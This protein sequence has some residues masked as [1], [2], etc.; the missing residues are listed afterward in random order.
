MADLRLVRKS[1]GVI[2]PGLAFDLRARRLGAHI[3]HGLL[4]ALCCVLLACTGGDPAPGAGKVLFVGNS[5]TYVGNV[6]AVYSA[7]SSANGRESPS[8]MIVRGGATLAQRV[9]DG[10]VARALE[11]GAYRTLVIQERGGDLVCGF[12]PESCARSKEAVTSLARLG[13]EHQV[14]VLLLGTY[15]PDAS[16]SRRLVEGESMAAREAGIGYIE[17]SEKLQRLRTAAPDLSWFAADDFHPGKHLA[18][19]NALLVYQAV[20]DTLPAPGQLTV[21]APIYEST[22]GLTQAPRA[23]DAP[24][25]LSTTPRRVH[26]EAEAVDRL[27]A[28]LEASAED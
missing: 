22:S 1:R 21:V 4:L 26:Y 3:R 6:P 27:L 11:T 18:L 16:A 15:Q 25:P 7:L 19:L 10:S 24:P 20:H 17:V 8:D 12:G 23:S 28:S 9:E 13:R 14:R 5:L 2:L